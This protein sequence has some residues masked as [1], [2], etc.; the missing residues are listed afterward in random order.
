MKKES[1][2]NEGLRLENSNVAMPEIGFVI[3][4]VGLSTI[5]IASGYG[6]PYILVKILSLI[7]YLLAIWGGFIFY[8][9]L[10]FEKIPKTMEAWWNR[11][12]GR[13]TF[14]GARWIFGHWI[15]LA[16]YTGIVLTKKRRAET[17]EC[18]YLTILLALFLYWCAGIALYVIGFIEFI[19]KSK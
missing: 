8:W 6:S 7:I 14:A 18:A 19:Y 2:S 16:F 11:K 10:L 9:H 15:K 12:R 4:A 17:L 3:V 13:F 5:A 1:T